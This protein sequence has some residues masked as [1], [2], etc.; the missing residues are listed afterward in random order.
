MGGDGGRGGGAVDGA[1]F[2]VLPVLE[3]EELSKLQDDLLDG[4]HVT[5][6]DLCEFLLLLLLLCIRC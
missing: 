3:G 6:H 1:G 2:G 4:V 5:H